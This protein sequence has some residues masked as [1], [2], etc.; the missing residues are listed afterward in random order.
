MA[1]KFLGHQALA[2]QP[3]QQKDFILICIWFPFLIKIG[4]YFIPFCVG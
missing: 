4:L 2:V 3:K 1:A